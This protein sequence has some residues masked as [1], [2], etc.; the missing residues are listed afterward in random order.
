MKKKCVFL[1][2]AACLVFTGCHRMKG[3]CG[4][5]QDE[6]GFISLFDGTMNG[7]KAS[8]N[9]GT[10]KIENGLLVAHGARSHLFYDG[11]VQNHNFKNFELRIDVKTTLGSNAGI[12]F[13]TEYQEKGWPKK[14]YEVQV[15]ATHTDKKKGGGLYGVV[16][17]YPAPVGDD[18]WYTQSIVVN[19]K[20]VLLSINGKLMVDY[21]EPPEVTAAPAPRRQISNGTIALQGHDPKSIVYFKNIRIKPLP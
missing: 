14:G 12:Y 4:M 9:K 8:E 13:H 21:K 2:L 15:N 5:C 16:D 6:E 3:C 20:N 19:G 1:L 18:E 11:P 7:W 10:F 17:L